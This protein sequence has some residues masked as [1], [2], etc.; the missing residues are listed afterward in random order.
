MTQFDIPDV[1][2]WEILLGFVCFM[3]DVFFVAVIAVF[4]F[5]G[6]E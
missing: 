5:G 3:L 1:S 4:F 2:V 6:D